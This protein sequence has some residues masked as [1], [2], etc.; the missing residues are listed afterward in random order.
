MKKHWFQTLAVLLC[1]MICLG[2]LG[3]AKTAEYTV[4]VCQLSTHNALDEATKGFCDAL[5][6]QLGDDVDIRI[7]SASGDSNTV[8]SIMNAFVAD[9]VDLIVANSTP[10]LQN[11]AA[12]TTDIPILGTAVTEYGAALGIDAFGGIVGGNVSG[13][14]DLAPLDAQA[15]MIEEWFPAGDYPNVGMLYCSSEA[16]SI[17]QIET[18]GVLLEEKGYTCTVYPFADSND[19]A[20]VTTDAA[21]HSDV[22]FVPTDNR[23]ADNVTIIDNICRGVVPVIGGD[24]AICAACGVAAISV[25][26]YDMGYATGLMAAKVLTGEETISDMPIAYADI[27]TVCYNPDTCAALSIT[28]PDD[29]Y[30]IVNK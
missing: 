25:E 19:I 28:V 30:E 4:G 5:Q 6:A 13:T 24:E 18:V 29:R 17:Y 10:V 12:A 26:Y 22:I 1:A 7:E 11:A 16:N 15:D 14:S 3:C 23:V 9:Q 8:S 2:A 27:F 21:A 20:A